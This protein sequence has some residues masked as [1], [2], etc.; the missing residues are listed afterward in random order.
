M[1]THHEKE[2]FR[3]AY[4]RLTPEQRRQFR[5][6]LQKFVDDLREME[7]GQRQ[8]FRPG[9][10]VSSLKADPRKYEMTWAGNGR[11]VFAW[12]TPQRPGFRH[13]EWLDIGG[14]EILP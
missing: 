4:R 7:T 12:G 8:R 1:P 14:H 2:A 6:A 11:A 13:V 3:R 10:R 5:T 9:L